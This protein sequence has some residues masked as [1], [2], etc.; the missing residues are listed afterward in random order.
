MKSVGILVYR[1]AGTTEESAEPSV[2]DEADKVL[3]L[4]HRTRAKVIF[5]IK[6]TTSHNLHNAVFGT[7]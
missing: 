6:H 3:F 7:L 2:G 1:Y 4:I 5:K